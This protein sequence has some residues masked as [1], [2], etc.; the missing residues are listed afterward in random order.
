MDIPGPAFR[1]GGNIIVCGCVKIDPSNDNQ[2]L[3]CTGL[4]DGIIVGV[5]QEGQSLA[6][7]LVGSNSV[8]AATSG[9]NVKVAGIG[10]VALVQLA[11]TATRGL[12]AEIYNASGWVGNTTGS[13]A[14]QTA[15][16]FLQS[17]VT[18]DWVDMVV[19]PQ[20]IYT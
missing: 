1:A 11:T 7:G 16:V 3:M 19:F 2:V 8:L 14:R 5:A 17:G 10:N 15:G 12:R 20:A 9:M 4:A 18:G 13:G 6:P